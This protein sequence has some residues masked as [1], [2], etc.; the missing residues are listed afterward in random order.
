[1]NLSNFLTISRIII[2]PLICA[3]IL[4]DNYIFALYSFIF[5]SLTDFFDGFI[6]RKSNKVTNSG[7][8]LDP[9]SDKI[10][11]FS[12]LSCF[13][14]M[15]MLNIWAFI[16]LLSRDFIISSLRIILAK[17]DIVYEANTLGK[18]KT[19]FQ[20]LFIFILL[21]SNGNKMNFIFFSEFFVWISVILSII[22]LISCIIDN[23]SILLKEFR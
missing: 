11:A 3:L 10:L 18:L 6:A 1:M 12:I 5:A 17:N 22:S 8:I 9:I 4:S 14:K 2:T 7:K 21:L 19:V 23:K 15:K 16:I 20:F 13:V